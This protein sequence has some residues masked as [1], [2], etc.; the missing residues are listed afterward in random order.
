M[1]QFI[2]LA[3]FAFSSVT[4]V[5]VVASSSVTNSSSSLEQNQTPVSET[6]STLL[7]EATVL[8]RNWHRSDLFGTFW[9]G[10][11]GNWVNHL[12]LGWLYV[13]SDLQGTSYWLYSPG[14]GWLWTK[15]SVHPWTYRY[16]AKSWMYLSPED[17]SKRMY[18]YAKGVWKKRS[19]DRWY[20]WGG[21]KY[22][23]MGKIDSSGE[24]GNSSMEVVVES[25]TVFSDEAKPTLDGTSYQFEE[26]VIVNGTLDVK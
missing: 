18:D 7:G 16:S 5:V 23:L 24:L 15:R 8:G 21:G 2:L 14:L 13:Q 20:G 6:A 1:K 17:G 22:H 10:S 12:S 19:G 4:S 3:I 26:D 9:Q 11:Q 25:G